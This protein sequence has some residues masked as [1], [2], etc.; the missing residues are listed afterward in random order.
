MDSSPWT[1]S[2]RRRPETDAGV[3]FT[4]VAFLSVVMLAVFIATTI[5]PRFDRR[6]S[7][8]TSQLGIPAA[9]PPGMRGGV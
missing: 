5:V 1:A 6:P 4:T 9:G 7:P 2:P 8:A 3:V